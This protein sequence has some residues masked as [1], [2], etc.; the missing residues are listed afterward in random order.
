MKTRKAVEIALV[1]K[2]KVGVLASVCEILAKAGVNIE[3]MCGYSCGE[4]AN[5]TIV[6]DKTAKA[7]AAFKKAGIRAKT[8]KVLMVEMPNK[9][10]ALADAGKRLEKA[11]VSVEYLYATTCG[12]NGRVV[13]CARNLEKMAR[14]LA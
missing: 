12:R 8:G 6:A 9:T 5:L 4:T 2:D 10:G 7:L 1:L 14:A 13:M 11:G 3:A